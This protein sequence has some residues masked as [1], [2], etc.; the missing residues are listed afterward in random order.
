MTVK[1]IGGGLAGCEACY[2]LAKRGIKTILYEMRPKKFTPCHS[3]GNL[4]ELVCSNSLKSIGL[5]TASGL[6]KEEMSVL[7]SLIIKCAKECS[8]PSGSAL[9]VDRAL[10]SEKV[11]EKLLSLSDFKLVTDEVID[12]DKDEYTIIASGPLTSDS[13]AVSIKELIGCDYL[14]FFDAASPI[15]SAESIDYDKA[16]FASRYGKGDRFDYLNL[17]MNKEEYDLFLNE[18]IHAKCAEVKGFEKNLVFEGCMPVEVMAL[19]GEN[20]L[21]FGPLKPVGLYNEGKKYYA[22]V[23]LRRENKEGTMYN[24]VGFQTHLTFPEQK[25]VFSL[26]PA[27]KN[28]EFLRYGVMHRNTFINSPEILNSDLSMKKYGKIFFAGQIT[29]VE[30]YVESAAAGL[31]AGINT[32]LKI[33]GEETLIPS[34]NTIIGSLLRYI[35]SNVDNFQPMNANFGLLKPLD[36]VIKDKQ[37]R[38]KEF[39]KRAVNDII[40]FNDTVKNI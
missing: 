29:G 11:T 10:F 12:I 3:T 39:S 13:L 22:V 35:T 31:I 5:E 2:Q 40:K 33:K 34:E 17:P 6:L 37:L 24:I 4:C 1:V 36:T 20:T 8:V 27:L 26:I 38:K 9:S 19:R 32:A 30:G 7:D 14:H 18:L 21:R 15:V 23:Q 16:F 28:A 25:R